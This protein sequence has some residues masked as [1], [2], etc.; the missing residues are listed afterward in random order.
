MP[1]GSRRPQPD[2][3]E[4]RPKKPTPTNPSGANPDAPGPR[5]RVKVSDIADEFGDAA[6]KQYKKILAEYG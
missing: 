6:S 2:A 1:D 4:G 3:P 5:G